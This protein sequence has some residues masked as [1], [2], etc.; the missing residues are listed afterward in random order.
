MTADEMT[1]WLHWGG[2]TPTKVFESAAA[3]YLLLP[4]V[5]PSR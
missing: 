5:P 3:N 1:A 2:G 4:I